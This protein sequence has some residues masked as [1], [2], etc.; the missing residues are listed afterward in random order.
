MKHL[1][2]LCASLVLI[3]KTY[4]QS[5]LTWSRDFSTG[6][7]NYYS[8]F[9][10]IQEDAD[11]LEV[12]GRKNTPNGQ[13]L[14]VVKYNLLGDTISTKTFGNNLVVN[15]EIIDYK[16]DSLDNIYI[17][18]KEKIGFY[19]SKIILQKYSL[20]GNLIWVEQIQ[21]T[22]DTSYTPVSLGLMTD[23]VIFL[24]LMRSM[25]IP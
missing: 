23:S 1:I 24:L 9:P 8:K 18:N 25:T 15:N 5:N 4:S 14:L 17:L 19:K 13:R 11:T 12:I 10:R 20:D 22:A 21:N 2:L 7:D 6:L 16:F 3:T